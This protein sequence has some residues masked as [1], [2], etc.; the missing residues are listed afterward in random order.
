M[1]RKPLCQQKSLGI[2]RS[3]ENQELK[4][5][6]KPDSVTSPNR[7]GPRSFL[8]AGSFPAG[9]SDVPEGARATQPSFVS[10]SK[11]G[12]PR[13]LV[14]K[15]AGEDT[16][17]FTSSFSATPKRR[18]FSVALSPDYSGLPL[19][20][21]SALWSPDFPPA[22]APDADAG[23]RATSFSSC[24]HFVCLFY[25][26]LW[27]HGFQTLWSP[28]QNAMAVGTQTHLTGTLELVEELGWDVHMATEACA[29]T[30][31]D[32]RGAAATFEDLFVLAQEA[33]V[34]G[35]GGALAQLTRRSDVGFQL[36][37]S[38]AGLRRSGGRCG[39]LL[40]ENALGF[41]GLSRELLERL[42]HAQHLFL[43]LLVRFL[44]DFDFSAQRLQLLLVAHA[45]Q[46]HAPVLHFRF[47]DLE[48]DLQ[49]GAARLQRVAL[50]LYCT[51]RLALPFQLA[52][53]VGDFAFQGLQAFR[54]F[55]ALAVDLLQRRQLIQGCLH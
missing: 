43:H 31:L 49:L 44:R 26:A 30:H 33:G 1:L 12:L 9:S 15:L 34:Q 46:T 35:I 18:L 48:V 32:H 21:T 36:R 38:G 39:F 37:N 24:P 42:H 41:G 45:I 53:A 6:Y 51:G 20:A 55:A 10:C 11:W 17:R 28:E 54:L 22:P 23:D 3:G 50:S 29:V 25:L 19:A 4:E 5:V 13:M 7:R 14:S 40:R 8:W 52:F 2:A 16:H 47:L 27:S